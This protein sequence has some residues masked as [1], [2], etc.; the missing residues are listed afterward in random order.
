MKTS[1]TLLDR[2]VKDTHPCHVSDLH[3]NTFKI[4]PF[5]IVLVSVLSCRVIMVYAF[6]YYIIERCRISQRLFQSF[7]MVGFL[8]FC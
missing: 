1:T 5:G 4:S 8:S 2:S 6:P 3:V 7:E